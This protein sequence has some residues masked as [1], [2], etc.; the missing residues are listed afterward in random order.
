VSA[1]TGRT[2]ALAQA[3]AVSRTTFE[4]GTAEHAVLARADVFAD[5]LAGSSLTLGLGPLLF[6]EST[7]ALP[8]STRTEL[9]RA[10]PRGATVYLLGGAAALPVPLEAELARL[11]FRP[12]RLAGADRE[13]TAAA[14]ARELV[15]RRRAA[16][17]PDNG[18]A[19]L[20]TADNWPD[21]V[22]AG[23]MAAYYGLPVLLTPTAR[24][25]PA[26]ARALRELR[27]SGL[28]VLGGPTAVSPATHA[29]AVS[30]AGLPA[31]SGVRL[32]GGDRYGTAVA[33][34]EF[35]EEALA[36]EGVSP[37]CVVAVNVVRQDGWAHVL[38]ASPLAGAYG[39][40]VV[41]VQGP[42]GDRLPAVTRAYVSGLQVDAVL[43][44]DQDVVSAAAGRE[45]GVLLAR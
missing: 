38:S 6:A 3:V 17:F 28:L 12:H 21:A 2:A 27:P 40:V 1:G 31:R 10:L 8:P 32:A 25:H 41:P 45:L 42:D 34:A 43:A 37:R 19:V 13:S 39:C 11:G 26:T 9:V 44:G 29:A 20:A 16:D 4:D 14:V 7:G 24:L 35:F 30:A 15:V 23:A 33:L 22:A 5:A 36:V 18:T